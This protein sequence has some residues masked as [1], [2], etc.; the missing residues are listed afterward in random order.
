MCFSRLLEKKKEWLRGEFSWRAPLGPL[1]VPSFLKKKKEAKGR[2]SK[3]TTYNF[4]GCC[5]AACHTDF[6][7]FSCCSRMIL[8][9]SLITGPHHKITASAGDREKKRDD[10]FMDGLRLKFLRV[11]LSDLFLRIYSQSWGSSV[12]ALN[13]TYPS[14]LPD[15]RVLLTVVFAP[16]AHALASTPTGSI[17]MIYFCTWEANWDFLSET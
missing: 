17:T 13:T 14:P 8:S 5:P 16:F 10:V 15:H 12:D 7:A 2:S 4:F 1:G 11:M 9:R 3:K 6:D